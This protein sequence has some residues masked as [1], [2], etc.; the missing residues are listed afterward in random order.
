MKVSLLEKQPVAENFRDRPEARQRGGFDRLE[1]PGN[2]RAVHTESN[3]KVGF[4][5]QT[6]KGCLNRKNY[7]DAAAWP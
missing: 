5:R 7:M 6:P 3:F 1:P 4:R 2:C